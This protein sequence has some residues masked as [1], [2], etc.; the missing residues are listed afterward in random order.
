MGAC[1]VTGCWMLGPGCWSTWA[2]RAGGPELE[3]E[4]S[5]GGV[6]LGKRDGPAGLRH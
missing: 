5:G 3:V 6:Q 1:G 2:P 4:P